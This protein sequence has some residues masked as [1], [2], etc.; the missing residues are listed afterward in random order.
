MKKL[1]SGIAA[2]AFAAVLSCNAFAATVLQAKAYQQFFIDGTT[3]SADALGMIVNVS[4]NDVP[5]LLRSGA[6]FPSTV[7][8]T[9]PVGTIN[10]GGIVFNS[11]TGASYC[12]NSGILYASGTAAGCTSVSLVDAVDHSVHMTVSATGLKNTHTIS[13]TSGGSYIAPGANFVTCGGSGHALKIIKNGSSC[14]G[15]TDLKVR[16]QYGIKQ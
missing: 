10:S 11:T 9:I 1:L 2:F 15:M 4:P 5:A 3:Y 16:L 14:T 7:N 8:T 13:F 12:I 6:T